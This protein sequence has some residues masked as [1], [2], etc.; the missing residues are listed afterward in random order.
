MIHDTD[1]APSAP[2]IAALHYHE[3]G[4]RE[5]H[6][7]TAWFDTNAYLAANLRRGRKGA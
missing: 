5:G 2:A 6:N 1:R 4:W 7:P 3:S